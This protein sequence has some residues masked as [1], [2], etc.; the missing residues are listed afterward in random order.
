MNDS[1]NRASGHGAPARPLILSSR[2]KSNR[3]SLRRWIVV[4]LHS[5]IGRTRGINE[6]LQGRSWTGKILHRF[7]HASFADIQELLSLSELDWKK[8]TE[9]SDQVC[10]SCVINAATVHLLR[11]ESVC[12]TRQWGTKSRTVRRLHIWLDTGESYKIL[13]LMD[14]GSKY[15]ERE[16]AASWSGEE[17][18]WFRNTVGLHAWSAW[19][20]QRR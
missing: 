17:I 12:S 19:V 14:A 3:P 1:V 2:H 6:E 15:G 10:H 20:I 13:N 18:K 5:T 9:T 7:W 8:L 4:Y 16:V 11:K